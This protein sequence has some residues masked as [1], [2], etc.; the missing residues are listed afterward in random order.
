MPELPAVGTAPKEVAT[1]TP[2]TPQ[3]PNIQQSPDYTQNKMTPGGALPKGFTGFYSADYSTGQ[4]ENLDPTFGYDK[5]NP[6]ADPIKQE[7][8]AGFLGAIIPALEEG[9]VI[10]GGAEKI[11]QNGVM[12]PALSYF[13]ADKYD[14][15]VGDPHGRALQEG[16]DEDQAKRF[17]NVKNEA[18]YLNVADNIRKSQENQ[19][20]LENTTTGGKIAQFTAGLADFMAVDG[21]AKFLGEAG[22]ISKP[23]TMAQNIK[24]EAIIGGGTPLV[25][26]PALEALHPE[27]PV[28]EDDNMKAVLGGVVLGG[29]F[30]AGVGTYRALAHYGQDVR[31]EI[32]PT[33]IQKQIG[34]N[35]MREQGYQRPVMDALHD[36]IDKVRTVFS[37]FTGRVVDRANEVIDKREAEGAK[38]SHINDIL[39]AQPYHERPF[40]DDATHRLQ[41]DMNL[42]RDL[43]D[44]G[45]PGDKGSASAMLSQDFHVQS[46]IE[47][48]GLKFS[49]GRAGKIEKFMAKII[50]SPWLSDNPVLQTLL[51]PHSK[52][53]RIAI[54][55]LADVSQQLA[56]SELGVS[57]A[58]GGTVESRVKTQSRQMVSEVM[59]QANALHLEMVNEAKNAGQKVTRAM[60]SQMWEDLHT[61]T[62]RALHEGDTSATLPQ[63]T[64]LAQAY[65]QA[66]FKPLLDRTVK[67]GFLPEGIT[68]ENAASYFN[69]VWSPGE[70]SRRPNDFIKMT[71]DFYEE[72]QIK[73]A[74]IQGK[75]SAIFDAMSEAGRQAAKAEKSAE[76]RKITAD[77][78][79]VAL[80][81]IDRIGKFLDGRNGVGVSTRDKAAARLD[82]ALQHIESLKGFL[83]DAKIGKDIALHENLD[84]I[85]QHLKDLFESRKADFTD[86]K[87]FAKAL[88]DTAAGKEFS[89]SVKYP[90]IALLKERGGVRVGSTLAKELNSRDITPKTF[91]GLFVK[92]GGIG[93][94][95]NIPT[96]ELPKA[97]RDEYANHKGYG[98][99][100]DLYDALDREMNGQPVLSEKDKARADRLQAAKELTQDVEGRGIDPNASDAFEQYQTLKDRD[101][102][103]QP[104][105][106]GGVDNAEL[107]RVLKDIDFYERATEALP[108]I[109]NNLK[110]AF[111]IID[112]MPEA[113]KAK[114]IPEVKAFEA[115]IEAYSKD[116]KAMKKPIEQART[117]YEKADAVHGAVQKE[118]G[119][120]AGKVGKRG[121][122]VRH[123]GLEQDAAITKRQ[124]EAQ[125]LRQVEAN[126]RDQ[127]EEL[128]NQ[129]DGNSSKAVKKLSQNKT[130]ATDG[131]LG[132]EINIAVKK[133]LNAATD[134]RREELE[135]LATET[136]DRIL[137]SYDGMLPYEYKTG[138]GSGQRGFAED[139]G[140]PSALKGRVFLI[141]VEKALDNGFLVTDAKQLTEKY[142]NKLVPW[143][144]IMER[145]GD[146]EMTSVKQQ[147][148]YE[149]NQA[150][151]AMPEGTAA[152]RAAKVKMDKLRKQTIGNIDVML[153]RLLRRDLLPDTERGIG[154]MTLGRNLRKF[155][156]V[157]MMGGSGSSN[158]PDLA[159]IHLAGGKA[160]QDAIKPLMANLT[161][162]DGRSAIKANAREWQ[163]LGV[164]VEMLNDDT[165]RKMGDVATD[166]YNKGQIELG[167][168]K[169][170]RV[171]PHIN[172]LIYLNQISKQ[173]VANT[174]SSSWLRY[175]DM[176][177]DGK[178]DKKIL[179]E[180]ASVGI[181][182]DMAARIGAE[183]KAHGTVQR[184]LSIGNA[185]KWTDAEAREA[186]VNALTKEVDRIILSPGLAKSKLFN[187]N[188]MMR[189]ISQFRG[190]TFASTSET[191]LRN[192][193]QR[194]PRVALQIATAI[195]MGALV[196]KIK[197]ALAGK[198]TSD[199]PAV[200][201]NEAVDRSGAL[202]ALAEYNNTVAK[203]TGGNISVGRAI[204]GG[205]ELASRY[206]SRSASGAVLGPSFGQ[207]QNVA[208]VMHG[209][210]GIFAPQGERGITE[211]EAN[212]LLQLV[213]LAGVPI[214]APARTAIREGLMATIGKDR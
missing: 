77:K 212:T 158:L 2:Q 152:E 54:K 67:G 87:Q 14:K 47:Q 98:E 170:A 114:L 7:K 180:M 137:S 68:P 203:I 91:P 124:A 57:V 154:L 145:Y 72:S 75:V 206:Y 58:R 166:P 129:W 189:V 65:R 184:G 55:E 102:I 46:T 187:A 29:L 6:D 43:A 80:K 106:T 23:V 160:W 113:K 52:A 50:A 139:D 141:P 78:T 156:F 44:R 61:E 97:F 123:K 31:P 117:A 199:N 125:H 204:G 118:R 90:I 105:S 190:F 27:R 56:Q 93:D 134:L 100:T 45:A 147:I 40:V 25:Q 70:I 148:N 59:N 144:E 140:R 11:W 198:P 188:E 18:Q 168:D 39:D 38:P 95:D 151:R 84:D 167:L 63:A 30:G 9:S 12:T 165:L 107:D 157:T 51:Q 36:N 33:V 26:E 79:A 193:Q 181:D 182:A 173:M 60:R 150:I 191:L 35:I 128:I 176:I 4:P 1:P 49:E 64:K 142:I 121:E 82:E 146:A 19:R 153:D 183:Y 74:E 112:K 53:A 127:I 136:K 197:M 69:Q 163:D 110:K 85:T 207:V 86:K 71:A 17:A 138:D 32:H 20:I 159:G 73:K 66:I 164:V 133:I 162:E 119:L 21:A 186:W 92:E 101:N 130:E 88:S 48:E 172:G 10:V 178:A 211:H 103:P 208:D 135:N 161:T 155:N 115:E 131:K 200:W 196:Y 41:D 185:L 174:L 126:T 16:Y 132:D 89:P 205:K 28:N 149:Y 81:E 108:A 214:V 202:A 24:R 83:D 76:G 143:L 194:D 22:L 201:I 96:S 104:E 171:M 210:S 37:D 179:A 99:L 192:I 175:F 111:E 209:L 109:E 42:V 62:G 8:P 34:E 177:A 120:T 169:L 122:S 94:L 3:T 13:L 195:G 213:P 116:I 15:K 5:T